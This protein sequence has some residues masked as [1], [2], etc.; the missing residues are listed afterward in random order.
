MFEPS[1]FST[2]FQDTGGTTAVT[3]TGQ[4]V[5][6]MRDKSG[7][8]NHA[9]QATAG[10]RPV[11]TT[12]NTSFRGIAFDGATSN[13]WL[14][15]AAIDFS[16][17]DEVTVVAGV[18]K[19]SDAA[20]GKLVE[21]GP[22]SAPRFNLEAPDAAGASSFLFG[23]GGTLIVSAGASGFSAP[24]T[25]VLT[26]VGDISGD[27]V[28]LRR[29]GSQVASNAADQGTGNYPNSVVTIGRGGGGSFFFNGVI[30]FLFAIN[31]L[32]SATELASV[33]RYANSRTGAY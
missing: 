10:N 27:S 9:T 18:R 6:L 11:T 19:L 2:L 28:I 7:L 1:D 22:G 26:G 33:E 24:N 8:G 25:A 3:T 20:R 14:Q 21:L 12:L 16:N 4:A 23:S 32:L 5:A 31:R 13:R 30:T 17:S 15:T 29:N